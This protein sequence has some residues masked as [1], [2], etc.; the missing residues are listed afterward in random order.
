MSSVLAKLFLVLTVA[1]PLAAQDQV[2]IGAV[3]KYTGLPSNLN[4]LKDTNLYL[5]ALESQIASE[6]INIRGVRY[7]DRVS[8]GQIFREKR[9]SQ[10]SAFDSSSGALRGLLGRL[11]MLI[12]V[13]ASEPSVARLR[14]I[15][16]QDGSV[17]GIETCKRGMFAAPSSGSAD[18]AKSFATKLPP[19]ATDLSLA[20][21]QRRIAD[22]RATAKERMREAQQAH[23]TADAQH[24]ADSRAKADA[25]AARAKNEQAARELAERREAIG[26]LQPALDDVIARLGSANDFWGRTAQSLA[27][28]GR[29]LRSDV[30]TTLRGAD[31]AGCQPS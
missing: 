13:D 19:I 29:G 20:K 8:V 25:D 26:K 31:S 6:V 23:A 28:E 7:I 24:A 15:D 3:V 5:L 22:Q 14:A 1:S 21:T 12:V 30:Q 17:R 9:L 16:L 27:S 18:C 11:D 4:E 10:D 2:N